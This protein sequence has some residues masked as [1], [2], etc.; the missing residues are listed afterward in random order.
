MNHKQEVGYYI[1]P[2]VHV[3]NLEKVMSKNEFGHLSRKN[4]KKSFKEKEV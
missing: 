4:N 3:L 2:V 1:M